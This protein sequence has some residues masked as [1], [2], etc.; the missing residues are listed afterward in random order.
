[1]PWDSG[2]HEIK[3]ISSFPD[4]SRT[5]LSTV[6][7]TGKTKEL[8][9]K[10]NER[11]FFFKWFP[12]AVV[13]L[14]LHSIASFT[15]ANWENPTYQILVQAPLTRLYCIPSFL[16]SQLQS[17]KELRWKILGDFSR[18]MHIKKSLWSAINNW[19]KCDLFRHLS[20]SISICLFVLFCRYYLLIA[21]FCVF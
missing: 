18:Q 19:V 7:C 9:C 20:I 15:T 4:S 16:V 21:D 13:C 10:Q 12:K 14:I 8:I 11:Y 2:W 17:E 6:M 1:M 3:Y 5:L